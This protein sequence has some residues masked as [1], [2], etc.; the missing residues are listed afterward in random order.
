MKT[1]NLFLTI[2]V[3]VVAVCST[4][5]LLSKEYELKIS[6]LRFAGVHPLSSKPGFADGYIV[7]HSASDGNWNFQLLD[8]RLNEIK[9]GLVEAPRFSF[10]NGLAYNGSHTILCFVNNALSTSIT[11][12]ILDNYGNEV[13]RTTRTDTPMLR[14]GNQFFPSVYS[15]PDNGFI[16]VQTSGSGRNAGY[17]VE[18]IDNELNTLWQLGFTAPKGNSHIYQIEAHNG[19]LYILEANETMNR[20]KGVRIRCIDYVE[21]KLV[22]THELS[23]PKL[24]YYPTAIKPIEGNSVVLAGTYFKGRRLRSESTQ[25]LF[26]MHLNPSGEIQSNELHPWRG[27][28]RT[29][30]TSVP[31]WLFKVMPDVYIHGIEQKEDGNFI[32]I[33]ELYRYSG[34]VRREKQDGKIDERYHRIRLLDFMLFNFTAKGELI[35][36]E[37]IERPH[38]VIKLDSDYGGGS[39]PLTEN[40]N[41]G[42][43]K[44]ARAMKKY[45]AFTYRFHQN[46]GNLLNLAFTT[47]ENKM[48]YAYLMDLKNECLS[49]K[50]DLRHSKPSIISYLQIA[51][52]CINN[53]GIGFILTE[54]NT[55]TFCE[56]EV[57]WR[58]VLPA[59]HN[60]MVTYEYMPLNGKLKVNLIQL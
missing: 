50:V 12:V 37:R 44:R 33:A 38:M 54:L 59:T 17:T 45:G 15:H 47:Y 32:A 21:R 34:E 42:P 52:L 30:R 55:R 16:V 25:G 43:L 60:G 56:S 35:E 2:I 57:Y 23:D 11:Y 20:T 58:G 27:L 1:K 48:H 8:N 19:K 29:L 46:S 39:N 41:S 36:T 51:D 10:F 9:E 13:A 24:I 4:S 49:A 3:F 14:R 7:I 22:Y 18:Q 6:P 53:Q 5:D 28:R 40:A 31:D 26:M